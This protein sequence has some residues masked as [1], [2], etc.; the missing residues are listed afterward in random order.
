VFTR[1]DKERLM[2]S[3]SANLTGAGFGSS[4]RQTVKIGSE[5]FEFPPLVYV[6][7]ELERIFKNGGSPTGI[8]TGET[9]LDAQF[10]RAAMISTLQK[11]RPLVH[12]ASHFKFEPGDEANSFLLLGD[13]NAFTLDEMK[14]QKDL[15][16]GVE[17][18]TLSAC[19]TAAQRENADG[20]EV[21]GFAEL[22]QRLGASSVIASLWAVRDDST[23]ELMARFYKTY[24]NQKGANKASALRTA[25]LALLTGEY[26]TAGA[27]NRQLMRVDLETAEKFKIDLAK[28]KLFDY[29][30]N[31]KFA[32]PYFWSPFILV[33]NWK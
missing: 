30:K 31:P 11:R 5:S 21:D 1:S 10:T 18:L 22:A 32:H 2:R 9:V 6:K 7:P 19:D 25:Q 16:A 15:F 23:A 14:R 12:I 28:Q 27:A 33:G 26:K 24:N 4:R 13:G 17:L 3:V 29:A 8:L 20:R